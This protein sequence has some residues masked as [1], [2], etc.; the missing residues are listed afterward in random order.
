MYETEVTCY[1]AQIEELTLDGYTSDSESEEST[2]SI[3]ERIDMNR[4]LRK[5]RR[6]NN[7]REIMYFDLPT[8]VTLSSESE[9]VSTSEDEL[10]GDEEWNTE[11]VLVD[12]N[13]EPI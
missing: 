7:E 8:P 6:M 11:I 4:P 10:L 13:G 2:V 9:L 3:A 1:L 12:P 5:R